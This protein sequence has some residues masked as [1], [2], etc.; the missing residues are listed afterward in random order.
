[1]FHHFNPDDA[2]A[3]FTANRNEVLLAQDSHQVFDHIE[4]TEESKDQIPA[5]SDRSKKKEEY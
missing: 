4:G 2:I 5:L 1:M 3:N